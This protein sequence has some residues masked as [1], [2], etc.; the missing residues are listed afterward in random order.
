MDFNFT[1]TVFSEGAQRLKN[2]LYKRNK[3]STMLA[4]EAAAHRRA[5]AVAENDLQLDD[6][7]NNN[8]DQHSDSSKDDETVE[9]GVED[10]FRKRIKDLKQA[11]ANLE[12]EFQ[13]KKSPQFSAVSNA[14]CSFLSSAVDTLGAANREASLSDSE[15][16]P[17]R[18]QLSEEDRVN[19]QDNS[20]PEKMNVSQDFLPTQSVRD[21]LPSTPNTKHEADVEGSEAEGNY[22]NT[23]SPFQKA[24]AAVVCVAY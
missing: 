20:L 14:T 2:S 1:K 16:K 8:A 3:G 10:Y 21:S 6:R 12:N 18:L 11:V 24:S 5:A 19:N 4:A 7:N 22:R 13:L 17:R 23:P 9:E 15:Y